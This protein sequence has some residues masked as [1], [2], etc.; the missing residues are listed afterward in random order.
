MSIIIHTPHIDFKVDLVQYPGAP[1]AN[2][3][4]GSASSACA[5]AFR[6]RMITAP[7]YLHLRLNIPRLQ[8]ALHAF[9]Q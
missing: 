6:L 3:S 1:R 4:A 5:K 8:G 7:D 9:D 2:P